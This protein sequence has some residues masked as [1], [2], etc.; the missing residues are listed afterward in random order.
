M[1]L[2]E[3]SIPQNLADKLAPLALQ[4]PT[5][6][7]EPF[8]QVM[9]T[10]MSEFLG[11][12]K[13]KENKVALLISK[14]GNEEF[15]MAGIVSYFPGESEEEAGN[16]DYRLTFDKE[17]IKECKILTA[18][19]VQFINV[20]V[21]TANRLINAD[22]MAVYI[23]QLIVNSVESLIQWL[24]NNA[25]ETEKESLELPGY[26]IASV[27]I[28]EGEKVMSITPDGAMKRLIKGDAAVAANY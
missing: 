20:M 5:I 22:L 3:S 17:D 24:D 6:Q 16:W 19:S 9:V 28:E 4:W 25:K 13:S 12:A 7:T 18:D 14:P 23:T 8:F 21:T 2:M 26:F 15:L 1:K 11:I 10:A 27:A